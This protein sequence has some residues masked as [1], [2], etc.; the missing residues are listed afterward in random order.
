MNTV[1]I[2]PARPEDASFILRMIRELAAFEREP[3]AVKATEA[4]LLRDGWGPSPKFEALIAELDGAPCGFALFFHNYS[5]WEGRAGIYLE[6]LYVTPQ[7]RRHGA[8][9]RLMAAL[10]A[11]AVERDC[12]RLDLSVLDW[13]PA[14]SFYD[15]IGMAQ[16]TEWLPYR[17]TG[18]ALTRLA[19]EA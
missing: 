16:M 12:K 19:T 9:R 1:T 18:D 2:R 7:A 15:R 17:L 6:D 3:D 4:D 14:R 5:T 10:A 13:N 11:L 8:G